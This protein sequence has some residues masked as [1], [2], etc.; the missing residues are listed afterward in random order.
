[1]LLNG[2]MGAGKTTLAAAIVKELDP[3]AVPCSPTFTII[4]QYNDHLYH[5]DL[6]RLLADYPI[7]LDFERA[8]ANVGL[9]D[10]TVPGNTVLIEW[11]GTIG[12]PDAINVTIKVKEN[13]DREF[14]I[15]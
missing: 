6:Y 5:A 12:C 15:A 10:L 7:N 3:T 8:V 13:G 1:M 2:P 11:P 4:N 9:W 14:I